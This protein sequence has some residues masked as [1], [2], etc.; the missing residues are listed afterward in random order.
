MVQT[1]VGGERAAAQLTM[2][3]EPRRGVVLVG[4]G[5]EAGVRRK[6]GRGPF[7]DPVAPGDVRRGSFPLGRARQSALGPAA[8]GLRVE[9][10]DMDHRLRRVERQPAVEPAL[11]PL[12]AITAP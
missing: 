8:V 11:L 1:L 10:A 12:I 4:S 5:L 3:A 7:P 6:G 2:I 9:R